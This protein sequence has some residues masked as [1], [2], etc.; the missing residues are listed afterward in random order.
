MDNRIKDFQD[1]ETALREKFKKDFLLD[2]DE[3]FL[4]ELLDSERAKLTK[5]QQILSEKSSLVRD[6]NS[7]QEAIRELSP[8]F[9]VRPRDPINQN[10]KEKLLGLIEGLAN[11]FRSYL[12]HENSNGEFSS[13]NLELSAQTRTELAF[14]EDTIQKSDQCLK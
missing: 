5:I 4:L 13:K 7:I 10:L 1:R 14:I 6:W 12:P 3:V 2:R 11:R 8:D 9:N